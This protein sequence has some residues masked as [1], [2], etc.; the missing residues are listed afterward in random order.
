[1]ICKVLGLSKQKLTTLLTTQVV[2]AA[3][4][5]VVKPCSLE[6]AEMC[7]DAI[8]MNMYHRLFNW[9]LDRINELLKHD[10]RTASVI[11]ILDICGFDS[12]DFGPLSKLHANIGNEQLHFH[13]LNHIFSNEMRDHESQ[14]CRPC[15]LFL[16]V[17]VLSICL[18]SLCFVRLRSILFFLPLCYI[19]LVY[20]FLVVGT[21]YLIAML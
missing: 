7:R 9:L 4:E 6:H 17:R 18:L 1:M 14:V 15:S 20:F 3:G 2:R 13:Y 12:D 11:S 16:F 5:Q 8:A 21:C 19:S 10:Q